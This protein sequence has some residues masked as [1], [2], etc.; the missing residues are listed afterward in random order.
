M[1]EKVRANMIQLLKTDFSNNI[2]QAKHTIMTQQIFAC[3]LRTFEVASTTRRECFLFVLLVF[4]FFPRLSA[5]RRKKSIK[6]T[7][8]KTANAGSG[9]EPIS[10]KLKQ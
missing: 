6:Q 3:L 2:K 9:N 8:N 7:K 10:F 1:I 5:K 4:Y